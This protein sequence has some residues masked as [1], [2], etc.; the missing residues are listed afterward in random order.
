MTE[1]RLN[2]KND[3]RIGIF[4]LEQLF[5][6]QKKLALQKIGQILLQRHLILRV[7]IVTPKEHLLM[8]RQQ[9]PLSH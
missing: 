2:L 7:K 4:D 8:M 5:Q 6:I 1:I 3:K 9:P